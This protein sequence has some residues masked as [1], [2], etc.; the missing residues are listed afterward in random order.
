MMGKK[1]LICVAVDSGPQEV[2]GLGHGYLK[3]IIVQRPWVMGYSGVAYAIMARNGVP[4]PKYVDTGV[5]VITP[6]MLAS[7]AADEVLKPIEFHK[8]W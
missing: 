6:E 4:L 2:W 3:S 8:D 1:D 5:M 7:G